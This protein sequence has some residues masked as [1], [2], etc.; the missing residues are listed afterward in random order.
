MKPHERRRELVE[1]V[2]Q[3]DGGTLSDCTDKA[4]DKFISQVSD[5][6]KV[7]EGSHAFP[8]HAELA[9]FIL[10]DPVD[11]LLIEAK[12]MR[13]EWLDNDDG[14]LDLCLKALKCG[15]ELASKSD[16]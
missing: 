5:A 6:C 2:F 9:P 15:I 7:V 1:A 8:P 12:R 13:D 10:P 4:F 14:A 11:P 16:A 3:E